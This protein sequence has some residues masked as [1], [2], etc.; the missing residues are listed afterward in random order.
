VRLTAMHDILGKAAWT[1]ANVGKVKKIVVV[2]EFGQ[3]RAELK[4]SI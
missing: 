1:T 4:Q 2:G 3:R